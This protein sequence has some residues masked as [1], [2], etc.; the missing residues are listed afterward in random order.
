MNMRNGVVN[1]YI[2]LS[3]LCGDTN[4]NIAELDIV[5]LYE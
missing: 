5:L 2:Y 1:L 4:E 3:G